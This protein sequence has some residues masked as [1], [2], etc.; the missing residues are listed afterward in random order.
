MC[1]HLGKFL[2]SLDEGKAKEI[3]KQVLKDIDQWSFGA[4]NDPAA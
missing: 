3:V 1:K 4:P 2:L